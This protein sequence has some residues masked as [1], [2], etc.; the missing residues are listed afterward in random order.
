M[1]RTKGKCLR[2]FAAFCCMMLN[3]SLFFTETGKAANL[4]PSEESKKQE[5]M[6]SIETNRKYE[7]MKHSFSKG[8]E[9]SIRKN[10][11]FLVVPFTTKAKLES[12]RMI[13]GISFEREEN[14]P[15]SC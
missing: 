15:F 5:H 11:M 4:S 12:D 2:N 14:S 8:Y 1:K 7:G 9:P 10:T 3:L 13:V 6:I